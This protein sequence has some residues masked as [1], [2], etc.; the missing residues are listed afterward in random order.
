MKK[1]IHQA[2]AASALLA[3]ST[4][5]LAAADG[6]YM[7]VKAGWERTDYSTSDFSY[8][9]SAKFHNE[10][11]SLSPSFGYQVNPNFAIEA[12]YVDFATDVDNI[13]LSSNP[14][15]VSGIRNGTINNYTLDLSAK[16]MLPLDKVKQGL[17]VYAELGAA[18]VQSIR[19][20]GMNDAT[21]GNDYH[22]HYAIRPTTTF[23]VSYDVNDTTSVDL[24]SKHL[25]SGDNIPSADFTYIGLAHHFG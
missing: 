21:L 7:H 13:G 24:G 3:C 23:G 1:L 18:Y 22:N 2:I 14:Q 17:G 15:G 11:F 10:G 9:T 4:A 19:S 16:G 25:Y 5:A 6:F 8:M 20:G 12:S